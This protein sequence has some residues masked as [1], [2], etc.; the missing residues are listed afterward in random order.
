MSVRNKFLIIL[1]VIFAIS[2]TYYLISTPAR[3]R[4]RVRRGR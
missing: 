1:G 2:L 3:L 4:A